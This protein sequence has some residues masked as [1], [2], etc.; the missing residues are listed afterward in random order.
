MSTVPP[1]VLAQVQYALRA[2]HAWN[3]AI[4]HA[5]TMEALAHQPG[6]YEYDLRYTMAGGELRP[7]M[8]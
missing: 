5:R 8:A 1:T 2:L 6:R 7:R 4:R 3:D